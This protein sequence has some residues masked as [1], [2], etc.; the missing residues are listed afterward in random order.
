MARR[1]RFD[2]EEA[3][4]LYLSG[5]N[6]EDVAE[7]VTSRRRVSSG[8]IRRHLIKAGVKMRRPGCPKGR[9]GPEPAIDIMIAMYRAGHSYRAIG[10]ATDLSEATVWRRLRAAGEESR[11]PGKRP[12]PQPLVDVEWCRQMHAEGHSAEQIAEW[13]GVEPAVVA[14]Q[15]PPTPG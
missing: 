1:P 12:D 8:T 15:L 4:R 2:I 14:I 9:I 7:Q 6:L 3:A 13:L 5:L 10:D 11:R